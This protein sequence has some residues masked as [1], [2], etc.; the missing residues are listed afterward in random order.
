MLVSSRS[1]GLS[2]FG[3]FRRTCHFSETLYNVLGLNVQQSC[4][5]GF[6]HD[7]EQNNCTKLKK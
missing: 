7:L 5:R 4:F 3:K 1:K 2:D 6:L